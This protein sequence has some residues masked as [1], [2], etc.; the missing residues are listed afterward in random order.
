MRQAGPPQFAAQPHLSCSSTLHTELS[1]FPKAPAPFGADP[2]VH[3]RAKGGLARSRADH[4]GRSPSGDGIVVYPEY[5]HLPFDYYIVQD[6]SLSSRAVPIHPST[7]SPRGEATSRGPAVELQSRVHSMEYVPDTDFGSPAAMCTRIRPLPMARRCGLI[8]PA[9][10]TGE[11][12]TSLMCGC[13]CRNRPEIDGHRASGDRSQDGA[14][15]PFE[16]F[17]REVEQQPEV[18]ARRIV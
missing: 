14:A 9:N 8:C 11:P 4:L 3:R 6:A 7:H 13:S 10:K 5:C 1:P 17:R 15:N 16:T 2:V 12:S 18:V